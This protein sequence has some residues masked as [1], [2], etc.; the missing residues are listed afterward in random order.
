MSIPQA[1]WDQWPLICLFIISIITV[2]LAQNK[3]QRSQ[4]S[5]WMK[6]IENMNSADA[7]QRAAD[8]KTN[9]DDSEKI[10]SSVGK[11]ADRVGELSL[12]TREHYDYTR[13]NLPASVSDNKAEK[14]RAL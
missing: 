12:I 9:H 2:L 6:F 1:A 4:Q 10:A 11:L 14:R 3:F 13:A 5:E 7:V 8:R